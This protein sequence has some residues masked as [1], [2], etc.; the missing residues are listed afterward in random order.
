MAHYWWG[1]ED[2]QAPWGLDLRCTHLD[3]RLIISNY[4]W[5]EISFPP[6]VHEGRLHSRYKDLRQASVTRASGILPEPRGHHGDLAR[7]GSKFGDWDVQ[8]GTWHLENLSH[9]GDRQCNVSVQGP[10][11]PSLLLPE[12]FGVAVY[13]LENF[14]LQSPSQLRTSAH[15]PMRHER[16]SAV[17]I[18]ISLM[19]PEI[20]LP[21]SPVTSLPGT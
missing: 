21:L 5:L 17:D 7:I 19:F 16:K 20:A 14:I 1:R 6:G 11:P 15:V 10:L 2:G 9:M 18:W 4:V 12:S 13:Q 8:T 3:F